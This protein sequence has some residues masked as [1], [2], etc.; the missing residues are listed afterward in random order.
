MCAQ[1][2]IRFG[3]DVSR[4]ELSTP[5]T[6]KMAISVKLSRCFQA[7]RICVNP[8]AEL[9]MSSVLP[10]LELSRANTYPPAGISAKHLG[11][12]TLVSALWVEV[13]CHRVCRRPTTSAS[14]GHRRRRQVARSPRKASPS[15]TPSGL[16]GRGRNAEAFCFTSEF[17]GLFW[18]ISGTRNEPLP[19]NSLNINRYF[20]PP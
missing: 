6:A 18:A 2:C 3:L 17:V 4:S 1:P 19:R 15:R 12:L 11:M 7:K 8:V 13:T 14:F 5:G 20:P 16:P 9:A 10:A